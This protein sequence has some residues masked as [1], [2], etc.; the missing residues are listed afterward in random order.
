M[1]ETQIRR[2]KYKEIQSSTLKEWLLNHQIKI[3]MELCMNFRGIKFKVLIE[4]K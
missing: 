3:R 2:N 1:R 4:R